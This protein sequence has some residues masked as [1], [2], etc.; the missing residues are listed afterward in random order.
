[1]AST[2]AGAPAATRGFSHE[3]W[4]LGK[5]GGHKLDKYLLGDLSGGYGFFDDFLDIAT[6]HHTIT[7]ATQGTFVLDDARYGVA[8]ADC[9][10]STV[11]QGVTV[12]R[13]GTTGESFAPVAKTILFFEARIKAADIATGPEFFLG[14]HSKDT[15]VIA[16][17]AMDAAASDWIGFKSLTDDNILLATTANNTT[18][19]TAASIHTLVEGTYVHLGFRVTDTSMV[20]FFVNGV[21]VGTITATIPTALMVPTLVCQ[22]NGTTD[23]IVHIDWWACFCNDQ[24][25][26]NP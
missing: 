3:L 14:L 15:T 20:E 25:I 24:L 22:S 8:L 9:D 19:T 6:G 16:S 21:K 18:E 13:C 26:G 1:M 11:E 10:S 23:P 2:I 12:Q 17:S 5:H 4:N 7:A